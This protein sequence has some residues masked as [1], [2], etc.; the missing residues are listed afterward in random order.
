M[1]GDANRGDATVEAN[2]LVILGEAFGGHEASSLAGAGIAVRDERQ[3]RN[4]G[5]ECI[6]AHHEIEPRA[7]LGAIG[8]DI[9]HGNRCADARAEAAR[10]NDAKGI[11]QQSQ[12]LGA[13]AGGRA[14]IGPDANALALWALCQ[15]GLNA[16]GTR[17]SAL[18]A[19]ALLDGPRKTGLHRARGLIDVVTPEA[20]TR[21]QT[22]GIAR[23]KAD[24][25]NRLILQQ[26][27]PQRLGM[28]GWDGDFEAILSRIARAR[29][30]GF[31]GA[32]AD[33]GRL[34]EAQARRLRGELPQNA[35]SRRTLQS[36]QRALRSG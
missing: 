17:E 7:D 14:A 6:A 34:H 20:Q 5:G 2:P 35:R 36:Q 23:A 25:L 12:Y 33:I 16:V 4:R 28:L 31:D 18:A 27:L 30:M 22:Q 9:A 1:L 24:G 11:A 21:F 3:W 13:V 26:Q 32:E 15:L 8:R 10:G 29:H 19:A